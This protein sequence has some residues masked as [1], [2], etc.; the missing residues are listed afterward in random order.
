MALA[1]HRC[2]LLHVLLIK[3][4]FSPILSAS[5]NAGI[6]SVQSG[7]ERNRHNS[8]TQKHECLSI[9]L[10]LLWLWFFSSFSFSARSVFIKNA[11]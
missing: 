1:L 6:D 8:G 10:L 4:I 9:L 5:V 7:A 3:L 2:N 11:N